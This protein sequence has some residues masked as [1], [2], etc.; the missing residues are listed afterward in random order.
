M[1][2]FDRHIGRLKR[3]VYGMVGRAVLTA[4]DDAQ[5]IQALQ[6]EGLSDEVHDGVERM[7]D[8]GFTSHPFE[9]AEAVVVFAGGLR[10]H[11]LVVAVGDRRYRLKNLEQGEVAIYDDQE[12]VVHL[13]RDG[14]LIHTDKKVTIEAAE[15]IMVDGQS[16]ITIQGT[17]DLLIKSDSK[18]TLDAPTIV[19]D[20]DD[21]QLGGAG[22]PAV[23]RIGDTVAGGVITSGSDKVTAA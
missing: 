3:R 14:V 12:Q 9:D 22:G 7:Q 21:V 2:E 11:G 19:L 16:T 17:D 8:Y 23:A 1:S 10:S 4:I 15:E 6:V 5:G 18:I 20:S 13:K